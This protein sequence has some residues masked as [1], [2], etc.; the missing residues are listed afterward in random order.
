[1][2]RVDDICDGALSLVGKSFFI[3]VSAMIFLIDVAN[4]VFLGTADF[5]FGGAKR[6]R[7]SCFLCF[8]IC[9]LS[10]IFVWIFYHIYAIH[11]AIVLR[12][13]TIIVFVSGC[14]PRDFIALQTHLY[15]SS[16]WYPRLTRANIASF[17][18][19]LK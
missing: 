16:L 7:L 2:T 19:V 5:L 15:A 9:F 17:S 18:F 12:H 6:L 14:P 10:K 11:L 8:F 1:M 3:I 13:S 4:L